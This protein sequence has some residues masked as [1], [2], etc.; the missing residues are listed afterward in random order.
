[1]LQNLFLFRSGLPG[2]GTVARNGQTMRLGSLLLLILALV[3]APPRS[4][5]AQSAVDTVTAEI[6]RISVPVGGNLG[7]AAW[8]VD[9]RGPRILIKADEPFPMAS[10]FKVAVAGALLA[11]VDAGQLRLDDMLPVDPKVY[12]ESEIIAEALIHPGVSLSIR[13]LLELMLTRSD[14]TATD[15][16]TK[17]AGGPPAVTAWL[18]QQGVQCQRV[19]R[20]TAGL[21]RDFFDLREGTFSEVLAA[22]READPKLDDRSLR[23]KPAFDND[24]RDTST[25]RAMAELLT[26]ILT[27]QAV[28]GT[29]TS[30]LISTMERCHTGDKRIRARLPEKTKVADKTGTLGGSVNDVGV[31]TLP[32][33]KGQ[34][35]IAVFLKQ[36]DLPLEAREQVI[37]DV[38][39]AVYDFFLFSATAAGPTR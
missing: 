8:R 2:Q 25:P 18:R 6:G 3:T 39:R 23:P 21:L 38:A 7:L 11:R 10:T 26:R 17:A 20:D 4:S 27:G 9:G 28:S 13:N 35:V 32:Q 36:S 16:L 30:L 31:M 5:V 24:P 34:V 22:A 15:V 37:A 33:N 19:D 14:N 12:V 1:M 29:S